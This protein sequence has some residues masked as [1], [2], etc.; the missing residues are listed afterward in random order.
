M[1]HLQSS[2]KTKAQ[3]QRKGKDFV[4]FSMYSMAPKPSVS[5]KH[6]VF[7]KSALECRPQKQLKI[8]SAIFSN[9]YKSKDGFTSFKC[10]LESVSVSIF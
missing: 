10:K 2:A 7:S 8:F 4:D 6:S 9:L 3:S 1:E 5:S